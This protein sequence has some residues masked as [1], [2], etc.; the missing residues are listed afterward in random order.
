MKKVSLIFA[1]ALGVALMTS[2]IVRAGSPSSSYEHIGGVLTYGG[3][4]TPFSGIG[5]FVI[6]GVE[7]GF[8]NGLFKSMFA[9]FV[10]DSMGNS[11]NSGLSMYGGKMSAQPNDLRKEFLTM[12]SRTG[13]SDLSEQAASGSASTWTAVSATETLQM[14]SDAALAQMTGF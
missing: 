3:I 12:G 8:G 1:L 9:N 6:T 11:M 5:Q 10:G 7:N 2:G 13:N 4:Q 14:G